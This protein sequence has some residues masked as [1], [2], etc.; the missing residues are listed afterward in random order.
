LDQHYNLHNEGIL[1]YSSIEKYREKALIKMGTRISITFIITFLT[2]TIVFL[3][4]PVSSLVGYIVTFTVSLMLLIHIRLYKKPKII[5]AI[6]GICGSI[7]ALSSCAFVHEISHYVDFLWILV[8]TFTVYLGGYRKLGLAV[9]IFNA[10]GIGYFIY[11]RHNIHIDII[12]E[13]DILQ[14]TGAYVEILLSLFIL[15]YLMYQF[16]HFQE[17]ND[18][19]IKLINASLLSQNQIIDKQNNENITLLKEIHHRVKNNLQIIV[20]LLRLQK[21]ELHSDESR[22][23]FQEAINRV[24]VMSSI[25]QKLYQQENLINVNL[26][27]YLEELIG[28]LKILFKNQQQIDISVA[29]DFPHMG[30]KTMVPVGLIINELVSNSLKY[31]FTNSDNGRIEIVISKTE[32]GFNLQYKDNGEWI[33]EDGKSGFGLELI[34]VFTNQLNGKRTFETN[35]HGSNYL[36]ELEFAD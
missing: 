27:Q 28:E 8:C 16:I 21:N 24:L 9:L 15:A 36:F 23:Q 29:C 32:L 13:F 11:F 4:G 25:H 18:R 14:L 19:Q 33:E 7:I 26:K 35:D 1:E 10:I 30:L 6:Y 17:Y 3:Y 12:Q 22:D 31:A 20:S 5:F 34:E 2:L